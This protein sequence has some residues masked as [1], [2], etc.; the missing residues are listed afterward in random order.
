[1]GIKRNLNCGS[2]G[3]GLSV[4][5]NLH[6]VNGDYKKIA[7]IQDWGEISLYEDNLTEEERS[8]IKKVAKELEKKN[9]VYIKHLK[10]GVIMSSIDLYK[11]HVR[12]AM[13]PEHYHTFIGMQMTFCKPVINVKEIK[14]IEL[15]VFNKIEKQVEETYN[16]SEMIQDLDQKY[17][18]SKFDELRIKYSNK[19]TYAIRSINTKCFIEK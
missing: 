11:A 13:Y 10:T 7:H 4:W 6:E 14:R 18:S 2:L 12:Q 16:F 15:T 9:T 3:N 1:M 8:Y 17:F 5:D 19:R